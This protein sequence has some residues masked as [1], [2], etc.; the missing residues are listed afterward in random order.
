MF[1]VI[2]TELLAVREALSQ[3]PSNIGVGI[4]HM[5]TGRIALRPFD[6]LR[7]RGGHLELAGECDWTPQECLGFIVAKPANECV[8]VNLSQL[9][10]TMLSDVRLISE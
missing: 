3:D 2:P 4:L 1:N 7:N 10:A 8:M 9:N 5:P 6:R